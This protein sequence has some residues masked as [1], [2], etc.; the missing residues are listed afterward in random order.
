MKG[1][2]LGRRL[3][4]GLLALL[5]LAG[6]LLTAGWFWLRS[7]VQDLGGSA[8]LPGL[9]SAVTVLVDKYAIP[10]VY[11][12]SEGDLFRTQGWLHASER[13][14]QME[15]L[16]RT[17]QGRLSELFGEQALDVDRFLRTLD[18]WGAAGRTLEALPDSS[19]RTLEAYAEGVNARVR[20]WEGPLPPE[21]LLLRFRPEPWSP[22]ATVAIGK[23]MTLDLS[24]W[25]FEISRFVAAGFLA[26]EK[27]RYL[28]LPYPDWGPTILPERSGAAEAAPD[29]GGDGPDFDDAAPPGPDGARPALGRDARP[30]AASPRR[31]DRERWDPRD[32]LG[33]FAAGTSN[34]WAVAGVR[35]WTGLPLLASD[36][37]LPLR[38]PA[39]WYLA[40]LHAEAT[41]LHVAGLTLPG[42]PGVVVGYNR[43]I[44]W[45][46]TN[47]MVDD[48][49][50]VVEAV[51]LDQT[52][53]RLDSGWAP[54]TVRPETIRVR[55][56][57]EAVIHRVRETVRG[58]VVTDALEGV[59]E[60]LSV[61]WTGLRPATEALGLLAMDRATDPAAFDRA[62][63]LFDTPHQNVV[64]AT[65]R[66]VLGYRL[67]ATVPRREGWD[68]SFPVS[69]E[70]AGRGWEGVW[71]DEAL[72]AFVDPAQG[73]IASANN[74]QGR[75]WY[76]VIGVDYPVPFRA[77][78]IVDRLEGELSWS[79]DLMRRLQL[80]VRSGFAD[81]LVGR[82]IEAAG[83]IDA[84]SVVRSLALWDRRATMASRQ[85]TL[86]YAWLYRLR[87]LIAADEWREGGEWEFFPDLALLRILEE[88]DAPWV[89]DVTTPER[90]TLEALEE[91][92]MR[93]AIA[94]AG[95]RPWGEVH[96]ERSVH[97]L[98]RNEWLDRIFGFNVGPYPIPGGPHTVRPDDP[99]RWLSLDSTS[100]V[101]PYMSEYGP[102]ERFVAEMRP[103]RSAGFFLLPTGQSGNPFSRHYRDMARRWT[104]SDLV[105]VPIYR[106]EARDRAIRVLELEPP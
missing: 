85:T 7:S 47:G 14:W 91:R 45:G 58:P 17:A 42:V 25:T 21:F 90:E 41:D 16:R 55:G 100:W 71:P 105:P 49:D 87:A 32:F 35:S 57:P 81:R 31:S 74:L 97:V 102:S 33:G 106:D 54:F 8:R 88:G 63:R 29:D 84:D 70:R 10:H 2:G 72:P 22:R 68:G 34:A 75:E 12:G 99:R 83:R 5:L 23:V 6:L 28:H 19:R 30:E 52:Q 56:R 78:R 101:P 94:V 82:A 38:A 11:A 4:T 43:E 60:P 50:F 59:G 36:M 13:L 61:L 24:H 76:G 26:E 51:D 9:D 92:A 62:V 79:V 37:H 80:D 67:G 15:I 65:A 64:Y 89:D 104:T 3:G 96:R 46:F 69:F 98:G 1:A 18:L 66:G 40:A 39:T 27:L 53:Y 73:Y 44:A 77:R 103:G 48:M 93:D 20:A 95:N 86:F